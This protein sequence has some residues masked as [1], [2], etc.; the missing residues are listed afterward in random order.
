MKILCYIIM[1]M[2]AIIYSRYGSHE[3]LQLTNMKK[4]IKKAE[5]ALIY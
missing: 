1:M 3:V 4:P 2:K 5:S